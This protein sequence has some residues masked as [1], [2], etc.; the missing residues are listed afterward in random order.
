MNYLITSETLKAAKESIPLLKP[1]KFNNSLTIEIRK[2][3]K[4]K[5]NLKRKLSK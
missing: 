2:L 3:I 4:Q 1:R 5:N